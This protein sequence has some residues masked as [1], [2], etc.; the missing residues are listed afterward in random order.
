MDMMTGI[1][2]TKIGNDLKTILHNIFEEYIPS[3]IAGKG[4]VFQVKYD[5]HWN[6][7]FNEKPNL[8]ENYSKYIYTI[9][10]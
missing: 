2:N 9:I 6:L 10:N 4:K 1:L 3:K 8:F 7:D 5:F